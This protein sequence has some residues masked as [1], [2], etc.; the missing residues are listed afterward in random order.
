LVANSLTADAFRTPSKT[1]QPAW[2]IWYVNEF[3]N[4]IRV[5]RENGDALVYS[6]DPLPPQKN[7]ALKKRAGNH[8]KKV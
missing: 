7:K 4:R 3:G 5:T 6:T 1:R 8:A 2:E